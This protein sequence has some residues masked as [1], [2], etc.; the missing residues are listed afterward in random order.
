M[1]LPVR[2]ERVRWIWPVSW[3][4]A[5]LVLV[6]L[7][8]M[9]ARWWDALWPSGRLRARQEARA[10]P[11]PLV[12]LELDVAPPPPVIVAVEDPPRGDP[13]PPPPDARWWT[14]AW[15]L[16]VD[17]DL[18]RG[19]PAAAD[20]LFMTPLREL[21]GAGATVERI[22]AEPDSV[23]EARLWQL[24]SEQRLA[25]NDVAGIFAALAKARAYVDLK[26]REAAMYGE[27]GPDQIRVPE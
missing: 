2:R 7:G 10:V 13:E 27:F 11:P 24:V 14:Q 12:L 25:R 26:R 21:W 6:A 19:L 3:A 1:A 20:T 15:T 16:R 17:A 18:G 8:L 9:P 5:G 23:V 4:L 22:I